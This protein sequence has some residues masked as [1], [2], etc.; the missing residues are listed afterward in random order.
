[1]NYKK[2]ASHFAQT[3]HANRQIYLELMS[4]VNPKKSAKTLDFGCGTGNYIYALGKFSDYE[5]YGVEPCDEMIVYAR[6]KNPNTIIKKGDH[7]NIPYPNN[8]FDYVYMTNVIH[9]INDLSI[10]F[11]EIKRVLKPGGILCICT[12]NR[13]QLLSKFWIKYFPSII[14]KDFSRFPTI[15]KLKHV[16]HKTNLSVLKTTQISEKRWVHITNT[17]TRQVQERS[18]SVLN[19]ISDEEYYQGRTRLMKDK[20]KNKKYFVNRGY[21]FLWLQKKTE[22]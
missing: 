10:M 16:A 11:R 9:H 2:I 15:S 8:F 18:M 5:L 6:Q 7:L 17:I 20:R 13:L 12:E 19:L 14:I 22:E 4:Q 3:H 21:T 1:M